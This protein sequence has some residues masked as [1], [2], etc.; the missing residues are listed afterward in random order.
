MNVPRDRERLFE[1][2]RRREQV[3]RLYVEGASP[4]QIAQKL[5][6][7]LGTVRRDVRRVAKL[8]RAILERDFATAKSQEL[9]KINRLEAA[10]WEAWERSLLDEESTKVTAEGEKKKAERVTRNRPGDAKFLDRVAWCIDKRC[11][12]LSLAEPGDENFDSTHADHIPIE[13][14]RRRVLALLDLLRE[15][16]RTGGT[17]CGPVGASGEDP[18]DADSA[19]L[20]G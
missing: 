10:A 7:S 13:Q 1:L 6:I 4:S 12:I 14:R 8:W 15:R 16:E 18:N 2:L 5:G 3:A 11:Q 9:A 17:R 20:L 19:G